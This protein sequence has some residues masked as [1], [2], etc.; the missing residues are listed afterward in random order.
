MEVHVC[1]F[2][3]GNP[4][5]FDAGFANKEPEEG[6][7]NSPVAQDHARSLYRG[8]CMYVFLYM[9]MIYIYICICIFK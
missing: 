5:R 1:G 6:P 7:E 4:R 9:Y 3:S 2:P 8:G